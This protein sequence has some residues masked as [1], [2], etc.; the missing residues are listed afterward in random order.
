[1]GSDGL[2]SPKVLDPGLCVHRFGT[3]GQIGGRAVGG[4]VERRHQRPV[5]VPPRAPAALAHI[6]YALCGHGRGHSSRAVAVA[7]ALRQRGHRVSFAADPAADLE[8]AYA[9]PGLRQVVRGNRA[10]LWPDR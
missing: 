3:N 9:V 6:V 4:A 10:R 5:G 8:V 1:M 7:Q 2:G